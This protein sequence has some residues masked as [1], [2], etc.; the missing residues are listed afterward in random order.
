MRFVGDMTELIAEVAVVCLHGA[1]EVVMDAFGLVK[2]NEDALHAGVEGGGGP[3]GFGDKE[4]LG[5]DG[6][7]VIASMPHADGGKTFVGEDEGCGVSVG[8]SFGSDRS[9]ENSSGPPP[10]KSH[11]LKSGRDDSN[12]CC[13]NLTRLVR[14]IVFVVSSVVCTNVCPVHL[15]GVTGWENI[16]GSTFGCPGT[17][18]GLP[19]PV[20]PIPGH[21]RAGPSIFPQPVTRLDAPDRRSCR[22]PH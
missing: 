6:V 16:G 3:N 12:D 21:S 13:C 18:T 8:R 4:G 11:C 22:R 7:G 2:R 17:G 9:V 1:V 10:R 19:G 14:S 15:V 5:E 20:V